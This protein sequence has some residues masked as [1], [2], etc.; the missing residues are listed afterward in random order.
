MELG[1]HATMDWS[2]Q[3]SRSNSLDGMIVAM[4]MSCMSAQQITDCTLRCMLHV[5]NQFTNNLIELTCAETNCG[6]L[7]SEKI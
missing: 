5:D 3:W 6:N 2:A 7:C 1:Q 4:A